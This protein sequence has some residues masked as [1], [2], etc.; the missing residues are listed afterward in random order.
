[1][2]PMNI[3]RVDLN[4]LPSLVALLDE[5]QISRAASRVG[6]S[7]PAMSRALQRL[8]RVLADELLVRTDNE[9]RLTPRAHRIRAQLAAVVPQLD[10]MFADDGFEPGREALD[11]HVAASDYIATVLAPPL[12]RRVRDA[13]PTSSLRFR[14]W[15]AGVFDQIDAGELD[16]VFFGGL[17]PPGLKV[18]RLFTERF[19]CVVDRSHPSADADGLDLDDYLGCRHVAIDIDTGQQPAVDLTLAALGVAR[20]TPLTLPFHAAALA[21][22]AGTDLV[23]TLPSLLV[24][25]QVDHAATR[26]LRAPREIET[27]N[28]LMAW[29]PV[30]DNDARHVWL[31]ETVAIT[32]LELQRRVSTAP[33]AI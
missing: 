2:H 13:S 21:A 23:V 17:D 33:W 15:H 9:Y 12:H 25:T 7:Q 16:L 10:A 5:R 26:V 22:V 31:R 18:S 24:D 3:S 30:L 11:V 8:R 20:R 1:M 29:H 32:A 19:V 27:L 4:L 6:I 28:Y 14:H